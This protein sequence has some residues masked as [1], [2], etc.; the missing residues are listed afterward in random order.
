L[1]KK[2]ETV[3]A[4]LSDRRKKKQPPVDM[5]TQEMISK[6]QETSSNPVHSSTKEGITSLDIHSWQE[7]LILTGGVDKNGVLFDWEAGKVLK[8][9]EF[10]KKRINKVKFVP[11]QRVDFFLCSADNTASFWTGDIENSK[12]EMKYLVKNHTNSVTSCTSHPINDYAVFGSK[13][14]SW[15]I[16]NIYQGVRLQTIP[17]ETPIHAVEFHPDGLMLATGL[18]NGIV[19]IWDLRASAKVFNFKGNTGDVHSLSFSEKGYYLAACEN[20]DNSARIWDLRK[21]ENPPSLITL[22]EG[23]SVQSVSFDP[24][25]SYITLS[26]NKVVNVYLPKTWK[27]IASFSSHQKVVTDARFSKNCQFMA[28][29]SLDR[30][31]KIY[32]YPY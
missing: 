1:V 24:T 31:L 21:I 7:R 18:S 4:N 5:A 25:G 15:S 29:S 17:E 8:T 6:F 19:N 30:F 27:Q 11:S 2:M 26:G 23:N 28:T 14:A 16:H 10:H 12:Y 22:E 20:G 13:D 9:I 3:N 32:K